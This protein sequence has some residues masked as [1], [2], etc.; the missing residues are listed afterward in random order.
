MMGRSIKLTAYEAQVLIGT[1][2]SG[3][4]MSPDRVFDLKAAWSRLHSA[5]LIDRTDGLAMATP[6]GVALINNMLRVQP[7]A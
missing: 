1:S 2:I 4:T 7:D 3:C 5:G 6:E